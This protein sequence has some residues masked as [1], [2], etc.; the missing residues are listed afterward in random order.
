MESPA[1]ETK[2]LEY[3]NYYSYWLSAEHVLDLTTLDGTAIHPIILRTLG[4]KLNNQKHMINWSQQQQ[5]NMTPWNKFYKAMKDTVMYKSR[6]L[7][8]PLGKWIYI[9]TKRTTMYTSM[10]DTGTNTE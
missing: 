3:I 7:K 6:K 8:Q 1:V 10:I 4:Q 5:P 9:M 2:D